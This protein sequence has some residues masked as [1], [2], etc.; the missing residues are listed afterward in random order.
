MHHLRVRGRRARRLIR[1]DR[2]NCRHRPQV[3]SSRAKPIARRTPPPPSDVKWLAGAPG[4]NRTPDRLLRRQLLY[5]T[6]LPGRCWAWACRA[7][8]PIARRPIAARAGGGGQGALTPS[9]ATDSLGR[10]SVVG[11]AQLVRA[12][13]CD[14]GGRGFKSRCPPQEP[15]SRFLEF[16]IDSSLLGKA[17]AASSDRGIPAPRAGFRA[18]GFTAHSPRALR[19]RYHRCFP[20]TTWLGHDE[21]DSRGTASPGLDPRRIGPRRRGI[22]A[23]GSRGGAGPSLPP[24]HQACAPERAFG[25]LGGSRRVLRSGAARPARPRWAS[26]GYLRGLSVSSRARVDALRSADGVFASGFAPCPLLRAAL[27]SQSG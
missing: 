21:P 5:P 6:E 20:P 1:L 16:L 15:P 22:A 18:P 8:R 26:V 19:R 23:H 24:D 12:P 7:S 3:C 11:I 14:S 2:S 9:E 25:S 17:R 4:R 10:S 13:D 27:A